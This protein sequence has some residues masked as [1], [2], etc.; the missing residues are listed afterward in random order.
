QRIRSMNSAPAPANLK[1]SKTR[2]VSSVTCRVPQGKTVSVR[3][4]ARLIFN[5]FVSP[6]WRREPSCHKNT[7]SMSSALC[8]ASAPRTAV[9]LASEPAP[10][11]EGQ[12]SASIILNRDSPRGYPETLTGGPLTGGGRR[13]HDLQ[14]LQH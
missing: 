6:W 8:P 1:N 5:I 9:G 11:P 12:G 4:F 3:F 2:V 14:M 7:P 10:R 13:L